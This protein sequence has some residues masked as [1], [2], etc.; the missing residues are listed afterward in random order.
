MVVM[1]MQENY[2]ELAA[3]VLEQAVKD[4]RQTDRATRYDKTMFLNSKN[5]RGGR[6]TFPLFCALLGADPEVLARELRKRCD[7]S[8]IN[9]GD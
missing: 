2:K 4:Y 5:M 3:A 1:E 6:P 9:T 7:F 8:A